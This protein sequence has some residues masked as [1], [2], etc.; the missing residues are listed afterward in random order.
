MSEQ[1]PP[2]HDTL[3]AERYRAISSRDQRFDGQFFTA[4]KT[5]RIYCRPS[6]PAR[7]PKPENVTFFT[8]SAAAHEAGFRACKR[9]LPE[10]TPGTPEWNI[11]QDLAARAMRLISDGVVDRSGV[12]GLAA[13]LGYTPRHV[14]RTLVAELG[15]SPVSLARAKRAQLARSLL[16]GTDLKLADAAF[17]AGFGSIRQFNDTMRAVFDAQPSAIR[18]RAQHSTATLTS[19]STVLGPRIQVT[20]SLPVRAPFDALGVFEFLAA[21]AIVGVEQADLSDPSHLMYARTVALPSGPGAFRIRATRMP[22]VR[23]A[24]VAAHASLTEAETRQL[25]Q[26]WR[27]HADLELSELSDIPVVLARIRRLLDLDADCE[28]IDQA[29]LHDPHL[30]PLVERTPGIR[31][32]GS[33]DP[34]EMVIRAIVGQ[35]ISVPAARGHLARLANIAGRPY[36]SGFD[37]L[38]TLFPAPEQIANA[39]VPVSQDTPLDPDR[40]LRLPRRSMTAIHTAARRLATGE[41]QVHIGADGTQLTQDFLALPGVGPWTAAYIALRVLGD[42]DSW[43]IGDVALIAGARAMGLLSDSLPN[44]QAEHRALAEYARVWA[45]WRSY[46]S[47]HLWKAASS[48]PRPSSLTDRELA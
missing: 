33:V 25:P 42:S 39:V 30:R 18:E 5:T 14:H 45:P 6:C 48:I 19:G 16:V 36:E 37:G 9:C 3:F 10:A 24:P 1:R 31:V 26:P 21:R 32:P 23:T 12:E 29:L 11:R 15:A 44:K 2:H 43:M 13:Q 17:A 27:L 38:T 28:G 8:T 34:N 7:T 47:M 46:A 35:Q 20:L 4:V 22:E 41:L 40:A